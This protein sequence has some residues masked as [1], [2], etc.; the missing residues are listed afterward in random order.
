M[1]GDKLALGAVAALALAGMTKR[2]GG[3]NV[4]LPRKLTIADL[5]CGAGLASR[6]VIDGLN[7]HGIEVEVLAAVD[8]W[9]PAVDSYRANI[10][11]AAPG[12][13]MQITTEEALERGL[14]PKVDLVIT[15]PPCVRD[16]TM[17]RCRL[18][19]LT[20][21]EDELR[22][23][24]TAAASIGANM[25]DYT[26]METVGNRWK[27]WGRSLGLKSAR[28]SD[29]KLGGFTMRKRTFLMSQDMVFAPLDNGIRR[30]WGDALPHWDKAGLVIS[31]DVHSVGKR[32][33]N[34]KPPNK[35][36]YAVVGSGAAPL[37]YRKRPWKLVH[38]CTPE[39]GA[40]L[41]GFPDLQLLG[42][43]MTKGKGKGTR[44]V[45]ER[46]TL[47]GNGWPHT[48]GVWVADSLVLTLKRSGSFKKCIHVALTEMG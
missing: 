40:A 5:S 23:I 39:E 25:G 11:E 9:K 26:S 4:K 12:A 45:R 47:V 19:T 24:K 46:Q 8:P 7:A 20:D 43:M 10:P 32:Q 37:I 22:G 16:S 15:G 29:A 41:Q 17:A 2:R 6:G 35:P 14:V 48:F 3:R 34:A 1:T 28:L 44:K 33:N 38:R 42:T 31:S 36:A 13:V 27:E 18:A 21:R 30:G